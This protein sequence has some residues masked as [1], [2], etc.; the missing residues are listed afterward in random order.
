MSR[1]FDRDPIAGITRYFY[2]DDDA[3]RVTF[4]TRQDVTDIVEDNKRRMNSAASGW[5]GD[6]HHIASIPLSV[7]YDLQEKGIKPG[8]PEF[9]RW[10]NDPDNRAFRTKGG[11][12]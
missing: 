8:S 4:E 10:L 6:M 2:Y 12:V 7:Y 3:D 11:K 9:R 5:R 1:I